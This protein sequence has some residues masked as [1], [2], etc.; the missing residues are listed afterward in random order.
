MST[1]KEQRKDKEEQTT[2]T[3]VVTP[4]ASTSSTLSTSH[5]IHEEHQQS[6]NRALDETKSNIRRATDEARKEIPR[7]TQAVNEY[8]EQTIQATREIADNYLESQKEIINSLQSVWVPQIEAANRAYS[9][10]WIASP[11]HLA[12]DYA[13]VVSSF[14]DNTIAVTRLLNNA[15]F[16]NMEAFKTY[17]QHARDNTKEFSRIG[18]NAARTLEQASR[19]TTKVDGNEV[20]SSSPSSRFQVERERERER[21]REQQRR[22]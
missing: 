11:R 9:S 16:A 15:I 3:T 14:A 22:F 6:I 12:N 10:S 7:Y 18:V 21:E 4:S 2:T 13:R 1:A 19:D 17:V 5:Y 20:S 8:Q